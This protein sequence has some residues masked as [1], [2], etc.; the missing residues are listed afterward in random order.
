MKLNMKLKK[1]FDDNHDVSA[2]QEKEFRA[3]II[4]HT[5]DFSFTA[6]AISQNTG[7][8]IPSDHF[9]SFIQFGCKTQNE[10]FD[11]PF[12]PN[13]YTSDAVRSVCLLGFKIENLSKVPPL[14][15]LLLEDADVKSLKNGQRI[16]RLMFLNSKIESFDSIA[17]LEVEIIQLAGTNKLELTGV[18]K[19]LKNVH[20]K[21]I[22]VNDSETHSELGKVMGIV[23][24]HLEDKN[25]PEC[26]D[27]LINAGFKDFAKM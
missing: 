20:L 15:L 17:D 11:P 12:G 8:V 3:W 26:M 6:A 25:I 9:A 13:H 27:A 22:I 1:I 14:E 4:D 16:D 23:D 18:L 21:K 2:E 5:D 10:P 19:L 7:L 24:D